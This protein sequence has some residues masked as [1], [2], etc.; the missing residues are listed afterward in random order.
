MRHKLTREEQIR[1]LRKALANPKTPKAFREGMKKRLRKL[2]G[3]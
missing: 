3:D 2:E 1:G